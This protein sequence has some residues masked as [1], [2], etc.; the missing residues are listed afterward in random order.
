MSGA[1]AG[2]VEGRQASV[3]ASDVAE[4]LSLDGYWVGDVPLARHDYGAAILSLAQALGELYVPEDCDPRAPIIRTRPT[5]CRNAAPFDRP[6]PIGWHGDFAS[7]DDRPG[8]SLVHVARSDPQ[9]DLAGAWRLASVTRL[10]ERLMETRDGRA[11]M[12]FLT[13]H[14]VPFSYAER[15]PPR[16]FPIFERRANSLGMRFY[17]PSIVKGCLLAYGHI[18]DLISN[19]LQVVRE[20]ADGVADV[21]PTQ[22]GAMLVI[23]NWFALHDRLQQTVDHGADL[24]EALLVFVR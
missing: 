15:Q 22:R 14:P 5:P 24:R 1:E 2:Q 7:H 21:R 3:R 9:G 13:A 16:Y 19:A 17:E 12:D 20:A 23:S 6:A 4:A 11:T 18:P 10:V 8:I